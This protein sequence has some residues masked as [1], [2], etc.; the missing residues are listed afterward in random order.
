VLPVHVDDK[1]RFLHRLRAAGI[2]ALD[3]WSVAH[4]SLPAERFP[5]AAALRAALV[6]LPV[7]QE[8]RLSD[9]DR[10]AVVASDAAA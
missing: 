4:P 9:L 5:R 2:R 1:P 8:L 10:I 7:H 6:G 3:L